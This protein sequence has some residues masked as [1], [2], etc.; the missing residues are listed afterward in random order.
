MPAHHC[1]A[2]RRRALALA[3]LSASAVPLVLPVAPGPASAAATP[4][5]RL[6]SGDAVDVLGTR[7]AC[8]AATSS[9]KDGI[10]CVLWDG[11]KPLVGS[12]GAGLAVDGTA[13]LNRITPDGTTSPSPAA[14]SSTQRGKVYRLKAGNAFGY[15]LAAGVN[16]GCKILDITDRGLRPRYRGVKVSCWRARKDPLPRTY[17][18][19]V[20]D[21]VA[22]IFRFD[23]HG[24]V[25]PAGAVTRPQPR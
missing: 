9:G 19:T 24:H 1:S 14:R 2:L 13:V 25:S 12:F 11:R 8:F 5:V 16:L 21:R 23:A 17:G 6:R 3:A 4:A 10:Y 15:P 20:S 7:I 22:G 18:V